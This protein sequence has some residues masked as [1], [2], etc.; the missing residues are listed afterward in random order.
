MLLFLELF[1]EHNYVRVSG[2][3]V[4]RVGSR[5]PLEPGQRVDEVVFGHLS[6]GWGALEGNSYFG[7]AF[8][9]RF[10]SLFTFDLCGVYILLGRQKITRTRGPCH[11]QDHI[12]FQFDFGFS[13]NSR[14]F[15]EQ[16]RTSNLHLRSS[17]HKWWWA[18]QRVWNL[19]YIAGSVW[20]DLSGSVQFGTWV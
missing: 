2:T 18:G 8:K 16:M 5:G 20:S 19:Y 17:K 14:N 9:F 7:F 6:L 10:G 4:K 15:L 11:C 1:L 3:G 13:G 12:P